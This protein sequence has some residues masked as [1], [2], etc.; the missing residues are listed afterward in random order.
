MS[1]QFFGEPADAGVRRVVGLKPGAVGTCASP[2]LAVA[3][4]VAAPL[5]GLSAQY[6]AA[7]MTAARYAVASRGSGLNRLVSAYAGLCRPMSA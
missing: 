2:S 5:G 1:L 4:T 6:I 7:P 3:F